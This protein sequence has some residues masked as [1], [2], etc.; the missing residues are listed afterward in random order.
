MARPLYLETDAS[1]ISCGA[2]LVYVRDGMNCSHDQ[3]M[4]H[5]ILLLTVFAS[6]SLLNTE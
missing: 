4:D 2:I 3:V 1:G 6:K 5:A